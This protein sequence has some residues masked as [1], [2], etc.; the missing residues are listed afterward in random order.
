M[1]IAAGERPHT[2]IGVLEVTK[3]Q[4]RQVQ[5]RRPALRTLDEQLDALVGKLDS[6][7]HDQF[8][9]LI[10]RERQLAR[11]DLGQRPPARSRATPIAG[12]DRVEA[13]SR[14][15]PGSRSIACPIDRS[16]RSLPIAWRSSRTIVTGR[17]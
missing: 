4:R 12:S 7:T 1:P 13:S 9:R 8:T 10:D 17:P 2:L 3:P 5:P 14:A 11:A 15:F 16:E 6:L